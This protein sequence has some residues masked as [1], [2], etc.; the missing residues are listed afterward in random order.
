MQ[1][2]HS[3]FFPFES[4][5]FFFCRLSLSLSPY[6][7]KP[8]VYLNL[9]SNSAC[10]TAFL[11][12]LLYIQ[13]VLFSLSDN[14]LYSIICLDRIVY[15]HFAVLPKSQIHFDILPLHF[16]TLLPSGIK[17]R[18]EG[19]KTGGFGLSSPTT[20]RIL[21][22]NLIINF[23]SDKTLSCSIYLTRVMKFKCWFAKASDI[24]SWSLE[25]QVIIAHRYMRIPHHTP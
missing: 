25:R 16:P 8:L 10:F 22:D 20:P 11:S 21:R 14:N 18:E 6:L 5:V 17:M 2:V 4:I 9:L 15:P 7:P 24:R 13:T 3:F 23:E 19:G 1:A 12:I